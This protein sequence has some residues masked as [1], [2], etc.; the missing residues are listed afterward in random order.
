MKTYHQRR[1][2]GTDT[3]WMRTFSDLS[4]DQK[5]ATALLQVGTFL[6]YFDLSKIYHDPLTSHLSQPWQP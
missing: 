2:Y 4:R 5:E 6:E 3:A 1:S